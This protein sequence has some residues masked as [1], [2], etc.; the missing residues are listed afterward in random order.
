MR[1]I[2]PLLLMLIISLCGCSVKE[3]VPLEC[4]SDTL[5]APSAPSFYIRADIPAQAVLSD[6]CKDGCCAVFSHED[7]EIYQEIFP[8]S[9][10]DE[11][12]LRLTGRTEL[13]L[14]QTNDFPMP[15]YRF[16]YLA[17]G[18]GG[19]Q[20]FCGKLIFDGTHCYSLI[21]RCPLEKQSEYE[22]VFSDILSLSTLQAV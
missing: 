13:S 2:A 20:A 19:T 22:E 8:A 14:I 10:I 16:R 1:K 6:S 12:L 18:E 21:T 7:Y 15:E 11:A 17:A 9:S 3:S 5:D 4:I